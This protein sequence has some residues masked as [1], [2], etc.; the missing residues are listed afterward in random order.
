MQRPDHDELDCRNPAE[1]ATLE[2]D[3]GVLRGSESGQTSPELRLR[4]ASLDRETDTV[5]EPLGEYR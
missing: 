3:L 4:A 5:W 1:R 2:V